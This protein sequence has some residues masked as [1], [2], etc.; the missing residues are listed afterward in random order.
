MSKRGWT[1]DELLNSKFKEPP[2][3]I[4]G[5]IWKGD[6]IIILGDA[7]AG[8][9]LF[10]LQLNNNLTSGTK[11][12]DQFPVTEIC[13]VLSVQAEGKMFDTIA[14]YKR[15]SLEIPGNPSN[16]RWLYLPHVPMDRETSALDFIHIVKE[17]FGDWIPQV[18]IFDP[19]YMLR[20][21]GSLAND[22]VAGDITAN[23]NKIKEYYNGV[24]IIINHHEHRKKLNTDKWSYFDEGDNSIFGSFIWRAWPDHIIHFIKEN[25]KNRKVT[26]NTQRT[27]SVIKDL[28]LYFNEPDP[29][30][31]EIQED[32]T[33]SEHI[34]HKLIEKQGQV[35]IKNI[36]ELLPLDYSESTIYKSLRRLCLRKVIRREGRGQYVVC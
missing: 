11:F 13:N 22:E 30:F 10:T 33:Q 4:P 28:K 6:N 18:I 12:L 34:I 14:R 3:L 21:K 32:T 36:V 31:F 9:S 17:E 27:G 23:L 8:K 7:K 26:C 15:M 1:G 16:L 29:L 35:T 25:D 24:T 20:S 19:L 2:A 5:F